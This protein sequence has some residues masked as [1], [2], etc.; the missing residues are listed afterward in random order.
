VIKTNTYIRKSQKYLNYNADEK[1]KLISSQKECSCRK[2]KFENNLLE[3]YTHA[4]WSDK[5]D[6]FP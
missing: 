1:K 2:F 4:K 5:K 6:T 3:K